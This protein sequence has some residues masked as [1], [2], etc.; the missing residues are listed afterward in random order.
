M[1]LIIKYSFLIVICCLINCKNSKRESDANKQLVKP[2][3]KIIPKY[4]K[5]YFDYDQ[6]DYYHTDI[7]ED[8]AMDLFDNQDKSKKNKLKFEVIIGET[9]K[10]I[11]DSGFIKNLNGIGFKRFKI[12]SN[13]FK[14]IDSIFVEK[15]TN[16]GI[17]SSCIAIY[18]D[19]LIFRKQKKIVGIAKIYFECDQ[20]YIV[21]SS[22]NTENFGQNGDYIKLSQILNQNK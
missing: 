17:S 14:K 11:K 5:P 22:A 18:R 6:I 21:G 19:I 20:N 13:N 15:S 2:M 7:G 3:E 4:G 12:K 16:K 10:S 1:Q 8:S 9:P